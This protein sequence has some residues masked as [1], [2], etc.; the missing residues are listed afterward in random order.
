MLSSR[1]SQRLSMWSLLTGWLYHDPIAKILG[2]TPFPLFQGLS[3]TTLKGQ[4]LWQY[5]NLTQS[6]K[7]KEKLWH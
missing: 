4:E 6:N 5:Y 2:L 7:N 3:S 1:M